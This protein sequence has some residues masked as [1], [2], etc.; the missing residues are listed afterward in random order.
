MAKC[1]VAMLPRAAFSIG[2]IDS[3]YFV[4]EGKLFVVL[5]WIQFL[6]AEISSM[7][8]IYYPA[9]IMKMKNYS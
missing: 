4:N 7:N 3:V 9:N 8:G 5:N 1:R 6:Q 2:C